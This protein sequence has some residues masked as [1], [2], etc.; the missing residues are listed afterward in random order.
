[1]LIHIYRCFLIR[2]NLINYSVSVL[3]GFR[4]K[5]I[6][7]FFYYLNDIFTFA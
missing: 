6:I 2:N 3:S 1:M 4:T 5:Q 7:H